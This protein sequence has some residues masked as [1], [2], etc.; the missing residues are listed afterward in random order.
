MVQQDHPGMYSAGEFAHNAVA[1]VGK[2]L[3]MVGRDVEL[4][5]RLPKISYQSDLSQLVNAIRSLGI[6]DIDG[7]KTV[8][9][10]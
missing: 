10:V 8:I 9:E 7:Q 3:E 1:Q 4:T 2:K 6:V 5:Q